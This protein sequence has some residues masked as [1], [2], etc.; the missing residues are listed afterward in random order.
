MKRSFIREILEHTTDE[1]ISFAG[2]LPDVA[3]FHYIIYKVH[4]KKLL[5][6][7]RHSNMQHRR[8]IPLLK[9]ILHSGIVMKVLKRVKR[10]F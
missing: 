3:L 8:D 10:R 5:L 7:L 6:P 2:G 9:S 4:P 1:T